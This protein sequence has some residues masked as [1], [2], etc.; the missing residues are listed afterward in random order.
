M[1]A[2]LDSFAKRHSDTLYA[3]FRIVVGFL[4]FSHGLQKL[5]LLGGDAMTG[6][7]ALVGWAELLGG[8][9][10]M[11]G[12]L[13]RLAA[14]CSALLMLIVYTKVHASVAL[15]PIANKGELAFLYIAAFL[16]IIAY[17]AGKWSLRD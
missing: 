13:T 8:G 3:V 16:V 11:L 17:G 1:C 9:A 6:V 12:V 15:L 4:F 5:G 7:M 2:S 10:V 14:T